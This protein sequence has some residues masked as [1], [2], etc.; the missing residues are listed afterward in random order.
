V[1]VGALLGGA[2]AFG[3]L[4]AARAGLDAQIPGPVALVL[5]WKT[6]VVVAGVCVAVSGLAT[7]L[8]RRYH[9]RVIS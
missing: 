1:L 6:L 8:P 3:A 9:R 2:V 5:P 4:L 7:V